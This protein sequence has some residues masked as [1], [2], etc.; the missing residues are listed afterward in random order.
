MKRKR[1]VEVKEAIGKEYQKCD[2][3][4]IMESGVDYKNVTVGDPENLRGPQARLYGTISQGD[5]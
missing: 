4:F 1:E 3:V 5:R 2:V